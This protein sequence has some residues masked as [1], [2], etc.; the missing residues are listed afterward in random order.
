M[1]RYKFKAIPIKIPTKFFIELEKAIYKFIWN[2]KKTQDSKNNSQPQ[3]QQQQQQSHDDS[4]WIIIP[5]LNLYYWAV[6]I[7][8]AWYWYNDRQVDQWYRIEDPVM[9]LHTYGHLAI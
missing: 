5:D 9:N 1:A 3:Q 7:E 8:T 6:V 4:G 2:N